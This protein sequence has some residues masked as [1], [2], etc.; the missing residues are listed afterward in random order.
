M[1]LMKILMIKEGFWIVAK[2]SCGGSKSVDGGR[3]KSGRTE[4]F[5]KCRAALE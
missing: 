5:C 2:R 3:M 1:K 4:A